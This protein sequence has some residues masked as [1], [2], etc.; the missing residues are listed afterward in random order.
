MVD[1]SSATGVL[2]LEALAAFIVCLA[3]RSYLAKPKLPRGVQYP[4]GPLLLPLLGN[5]LA[6]DVSEPWVTYKALGSRYG[7][8]SH[9]I[10]IPAVTNC[11]TGDVVYTQLFGQ[12]NIV[13]NSEE[14]AR[15]LL[16]HRS[17]NYSDRPALATNEL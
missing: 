6:V 14:V 3:L 11:P 8:R 9:K 17:H 7:K 4:P 15:D 5:A 13:I 12:D 16:E 10:S 2:V 1:S